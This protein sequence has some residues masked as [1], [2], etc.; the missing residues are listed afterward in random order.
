MKLGYNWVRGPFEMIDQIGSGRL[1]E[2]LEK[3]GWHVPEYLRALEGRPVYAVEG[4]QLMVRHW[5]GGLEPVDLPDGV[6]RFHMTR[7][8]LKP[9]LENEG[10]SLFHLENGV[11]LVEFHTKANALDDNCMKIVHAAANDPGPGVIVHNDAQ[12]FSAG[13]NLERFLEM[14]EAKDWNGID[15]FLERFQMAVEALMYCKAPVIGAPSGLALGGGF[16]VL[17]HCDKL[18]AHT[19]SVLGLVEASVGLVPGG[20]GV[21]ETYWRWFQASGDWALAARKTFDQVGYSKTATSPDEAIPLKYF[22]PERDTQIMNRDRLIEASLKAI[23]RL[24]RTYAPREKP[25]FLLAGG[26]AYAEMV[27]FLETGREKGMFY[28]HDV[29]VAKQI[30]W[31]V[32]GGQDSDPLEVS[33]YD[34]YGRE[35]TAFVELARTPQTLE[36]IT[37]LLR[38]GEAVRN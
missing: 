31:I 24:S 15:H 29:T 28:D 35:R 16:E 12:H 18:V 3:E 37:K 4:S 8:T 30:A 33:E 34:M 19:N 20:G 38:H 36:R 27:E 26:A 10:A 21:K 11:R 23:D 7:C 5:G 14:I 13:V 25:Q 22:L 9:V 6:V 17:A 2:R 1:V 32:T